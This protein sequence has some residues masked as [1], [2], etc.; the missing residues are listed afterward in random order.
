[1]YKEEREK[2]EM[3]KKYKCPGCGLKVN[4]ESVVAPIP[5]NLKL[6]AFIYQLL[7]HVPVLTLE[8]ILE[9]SCWA[10]LDNPTLKKYT[11]EIIERL[12]END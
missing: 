9:G 6:K 1:L 10:T 11:E 4:M 5:K 8:E 2:K 7:Q 3:S 12:I